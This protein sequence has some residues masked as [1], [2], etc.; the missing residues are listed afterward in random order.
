MEVLK[1][2]TNTTRDNSK[3]WSDITVCQLFQLFME[4]LLCTNIQH[5]QNLLSSEENTEKV[6]FFENLIENGG[7]FI[8]QNN[9]FKDDYNNTLEKLKKDIDT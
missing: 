7:L 2:A 9:E 8:E 5:Y 4:G 6:S 3:K 1:Y